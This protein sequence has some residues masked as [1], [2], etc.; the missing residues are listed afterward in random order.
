VET[1][2]DLSGLWDADR[3]TQ[4]LTNLVANAVQHGAPGKPVRV[5]ARGVANEVTLS[6]HNEGPPIPVEQQEA[7]FQ[8]GHRAGART[9]ATDRRHQGLGLYIVERIVA[10]HGG[11]VSVHSS[12]EDGTTFTIRLPRKP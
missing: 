6:V 4:A 7:I 9:A 1:G 8:E 10:S 3:L 11:D 12:A 2:G 5:S